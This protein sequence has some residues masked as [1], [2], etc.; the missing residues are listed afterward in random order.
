MESCHLIQGGGSDCLLSHD[1]IMKSCHLIQGGR[2]G[3]GRVERLR[4]QQAIQAEILA[5]AEAAA[6]QLA[7]SQAEVE[8][9]REESAVQQQALAAAEAAAAQL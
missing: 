7:S 2:E 3:K 1:V 8:K 5:A 9:L 6:A 4:G